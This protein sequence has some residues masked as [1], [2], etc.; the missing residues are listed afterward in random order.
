MLAPLSLKWSTSAKCSP[1]THRW[2]LCL[3]STLYFALRKQDDNKNK[4]RPEVREELS[5]DLSRYSTG[6]GSCLLLVL[7]WNDDAAVLGN[8]SA[9]EI[10]S[11]QLKNRC[12]VVLNSRWEDLKMYVMRSWLRAGPVVKEAW[13]VCL[14]NSIINKVYCTLTSWPGPCAL[15][16]FISAQAMTWS[17]AYVGNVN[18][19]RDFTWNNTIQLCTYSRTVLHSA[20]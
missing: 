11:W 14:S 6:D 15:V 1:Q 7:V 17:S 16:N 3:P 20:A 13:P 12:S 2:S 9:F 18:I 8:W 10:L 5:L 4:N 19:W